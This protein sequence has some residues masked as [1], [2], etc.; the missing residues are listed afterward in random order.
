MFAYNNDEIDY[1]GLAA[2]NSRLIQHNM[3]LEPK[4]ITIVTN[5]ASYDFLEKKLGKEYMDATGQ[6]VFVEKDLKFK[7]TNMR[8][9]R[10]T[11]HNLQKLSFYNK[12][13][14]DAYELSPYDE[15]IL[16][17][18]DYLVLSDALNQCWGHNNELMMNYHYID[19]V[20]GREY[21]DLDRV[22]ALGITMYWATVVYF[23]RSPL[24]ESFFNVAKHVEK[25][26]EYYRELYKI[27]GNIH[28][29]DHSFSIAA[30][31]VS[32]YQD[33]GLP[34]LPVKLFKSFDIDDV[35]RV[36]DLNDLLL[37]VE[38]P[39]QPGN[40]VGLRW[41]DRDIHI[42]NKWALQRIQEGVLAAL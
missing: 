8:M 13:R 26:S 19:V 21:R 4:Q 9:F 15:T 1:I 36:I 6:F 29:N 20:R 39:S 27:Q 31:M 24:C 22:H 40:Y 30:H 11:S 32:G 5:R 37:M 10:D 42:M 28:R 7:R 33:K 25:E 38:K 18:A 17:D 12:G 14:C 3:G 35:E 16:L 41:K 34:Q 23:T 2:M